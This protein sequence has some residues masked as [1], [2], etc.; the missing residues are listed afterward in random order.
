[1]L[2]EGMWDTLK[3]NYSSY[4]ISLGD[5]KIEN[6]HIEGPRIGLCASNAQIIDT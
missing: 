4:L 5:L 2:L 6:A 3:S 1:M